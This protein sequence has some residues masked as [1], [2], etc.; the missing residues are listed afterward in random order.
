MCIITRTFHP[1]GQGAFY[2]EKFEFD[3]G[4]HKL[5]VY[6][7]GAQKKDKKYL[8]TELSS[9][10][11]R[12]TEIDIFFL[13]HFDED[14]INGINKLKELD[15]KI[16]TVVIP[17]IDDSN[18]WFYICTNGAFVKTAIEKPKKFFGT[19]HIIYVKPAEEDCVFEIRE[20]IIIEKPQ[21]DKYIPSGMPVSLSDISPFW[22][23]IPFN[24]QEDKRIKKFLTG[25]KKDKILTRKAKRKNHQIEKLLHQKNFIAKY[26][27]R[28]NNVYK[29]I[30]SDG[31]NRCSLIVYSGS[32]AGMHTFSVQRMFMH[33]HWF[34]WCDW[35][36]RYNWAVWNILHE[37]E[38]R[39][40]DWEYWEGCLYLGDTDLNQG[41]GRGKILNQLKLSLGKSI[42]DKIGVIQ[43][44]HHGAKNN[45]NESLLDINNHMK[46]FF[47]SYGT[48]NSY[49]HPSDYV[50]K[51]TTKNNLFHD[52]NEHRDSGLIE[53]IHIWLPTP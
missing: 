21:I 51:R 39:E 12:D 20:P 52:V 31:S 9:Y 8:H 13:S 3:N 44:P 18:K 22:A 28:I 29:D 49:G 7:C 32:V 42:T 53:I 37:K 40:H 41:R 30:C 36:N 23:Y 1:V 38:S 48:K 17:L 47:A 33:Q 43:L 50:I 14:H 6:D 45:Y 46:L 11:S 2:S 16:K 10:F 4:T 15:V 19:N 35:Y 27:K 25:L 26:R 24:F 34:D 5:I